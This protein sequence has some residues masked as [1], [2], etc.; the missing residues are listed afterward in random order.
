MSR[1]AP[2][3]RIDTDR[4]SVTATAEHPWLAAKGRWRKTAQLLAGDKITWLSKPVDR[5]R[6]WAAGY[7]AG[8]FDGDGTLTAGKGARHLML[9]QNPGKMPL[10]APMLAERGYAFTEKVP[11]GEWKPGH[12]RQAVYTRISGGVSAVV[13][14]LCQFHPTR[15]VKAG[16][17]SLVGRQIGPGMATVISV[18]PVGELS[19]HNLQTSCRTYV[20]N[21]FLSH[22]CV[23]DAVAHRDI[24]EALLQRA[25]AGTKWV[26]ENVERPMMRLYSKWTNQGV[27]F[28]DRPAAL[29]KRDTID[30]QT[31]KMRRDLEAATGVDS[32]HKHAQL[33]KALNL[34]STDSKFIESQWKKLTPRQ[35]DT[36]T[37]VRRLRSLERQQSTYLDAWL[38]WPDTL[39]STVWRP[40]AAWTGRPGSANLNLQN[41][42]GPCG[43]CR[44]CRN[45]KRSECPFNLK[46]LLTAPPGMVLYELDGSQAELRVAAHLSQDPNM[47]L[48]FTEG[49]EID[50]EIQYDLHSWAQHKLGFSS[51]REAKVRVLATFYGQTAEGVQASAAVQEALHRTFE[52]YS[53]WANK[54]KRLSIVPGLFGR[55]LFV[56]PHA[57]PAHREREAIAAPSQGG[58]ADVLKLQCDALEQAGFDTRHAIHDSCLVMMPE[59]EASPDAV[60]EMVAVMENA[61]ELSVPLKVGGGFWPHD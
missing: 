31:R 20:A 44:L 27:F 38:E 22:N 13:R 4:G 8:T 50:G 25:D 46:P 29:K 36:L 17:R 42:P 19:V 55:L 1:T 16:K 43:S 24:L 47:R 37:L 26:Y 2:C 3:Y 51:R 56:P 61:V 7:V 18:T 32:P 30:R 12:P 11:T 5:E 60:R 48:A 53:R 45:E 41:I 39:L 54:V 23:Q 52:V 59:D 9:T 49:I 57:N 14:F 6:S 10:V 15:L 34:P 21:G 58:S 35:R 28:L 33:Q 40:T